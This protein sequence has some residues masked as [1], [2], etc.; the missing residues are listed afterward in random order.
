MRFVVTLAVIASLLVACTSS[1]TG[2]APSATAA[3]SADPVSAFKGTTI[4]VAKL[5][6]AA[7]DDV[8]VGYRQSVSGSSFMRRT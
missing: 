1:S 3:A 5:A 2:N 7:F 8:A 6:W 4:K